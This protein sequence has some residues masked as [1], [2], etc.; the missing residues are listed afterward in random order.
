MVAQYAVDIGRGC[1]QM[2]KLQGG[3]VNMAITSSIATKQPTLSSM[4]GM[5]GRPKYQFE[6]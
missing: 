5:V 4:G 3:M 1:E 2:C 6:A